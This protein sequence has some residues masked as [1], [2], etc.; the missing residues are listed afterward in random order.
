MQFERKIEIAFSRSERAE[1]TQLESQARKFYADF[2]A[3]HHAKISSHFLALSQKLNPL[4]VSCSGG[5]YPL[6]HSDDDDE[7][8]NIEFKKRTK[9]QVTYS[10]FAFTSKFKTLI[11]ELE[12]IRDEDPTCKSALKAMCVITVTY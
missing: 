7:D 5:Q 9:R 12:K 2:K 4:R 10:E 6:D 8:D 1:Y 3:T 11:A